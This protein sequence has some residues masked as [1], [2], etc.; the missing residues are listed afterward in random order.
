MLAR[1]SNPVAA[2]A[3]RDRG[4]LPPHNL[5]APLGRATAGQSDPPGPGAAC[6]L[7]GAAGTLTEL[8][9][10]GESDI[11]GDERNR[12]LARARWT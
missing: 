11:E 7:K 12:C 5:L 9:A 3:F 6:E 10:Y 4:P 1:A 2:M 8:V